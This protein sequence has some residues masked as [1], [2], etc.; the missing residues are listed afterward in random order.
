M[1]KA[2]TTTINTV[3]NQSVKVEKLADRTFRTVK[4]GD[5]LLTAMSIRGQRVTFYGHVQKVAGSGEV[6][7]SFGTHGK[8]VKATV[9]KGVKVNVYRPTPA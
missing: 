7:V 5:Y 6:L 2:I 3:S 1:A 4:P 8:V 9:A